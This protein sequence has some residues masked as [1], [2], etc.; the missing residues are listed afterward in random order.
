MVVYD[1][2]D[3]H[4]LRRKLELFGQGARDAGKTLKV[5]DLTPAIAQWIAGHRYREVYFAE[6]DELL[7]AGEDRISEA[8]AKRILAALA[9]GDHGPDDILAVYGIASL[10]GFVSVSDVLSRVEHAIRGRLLVFFP[11][12]VRDGRYR[13]LDARESWDYHAVPITLDDSGDIQ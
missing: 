2:T 10:Y 4:S 1:A 7:A 3:E 8:I 13:L 5:L 6:P 12:S 9:A 11:G